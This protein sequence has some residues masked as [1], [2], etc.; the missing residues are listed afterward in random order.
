MSSMLFIAGCP[1][2]VALA[3]ASGP[4]S[5][6]IARANSAAGTRTLMRSKLRSSP[7]SQ[8]SANCGLAVTDNNP[9][10]N[11]LVNF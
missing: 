10:Q 5:A 7:K 9:G 6:V 2:S 1:A 4:T 3:V 8:L 11:A